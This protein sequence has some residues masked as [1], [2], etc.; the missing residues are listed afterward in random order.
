MYLKIYEKEKLI[1]YK[2]RKELREDFKKNIITD[3]EW[4][5]IG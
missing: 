1:P 2:T 4:R 3:M 5:V